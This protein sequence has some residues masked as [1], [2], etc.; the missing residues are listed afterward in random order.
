MEEIKKRNAEQAVA[1]N[2]SDVARIPQSYKTAL[3][4]NVSK[5]A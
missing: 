4:G 5:I 1:Y 2:K 3:S